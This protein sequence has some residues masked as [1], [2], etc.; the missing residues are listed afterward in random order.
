[1]A[2]A[3]P[4][5]TASAHAIANRSAPQILTCSQVKSRACERRRPVLRCLGLPRVENEVDRVRELRQDCDV[6]IDHAVRVLLHGVSTRW[7]VSSQYVKRHRKEH[8]EAAGG[9]H[10]RLEG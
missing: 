9:D 7:A 3:K 10:S 8:C 1:M 4:I 2:H 5:G 6:L